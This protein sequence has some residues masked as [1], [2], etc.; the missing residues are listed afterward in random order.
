MSSSK[1]RSMKSYLV[2]QPGFEQIDFNHRKTFNE[3]AL[4]RNGSC[5]QNKPI[6]VPGYD[7]VLLNNTCSADSLLSILAVS[8][9]ESNNYKKY[10]TEGKNNKIVADFVKKIIGNRPSK[11]MYRD[12]VYL[13]ALHFIT[14]IKNLIG[15]IMLVNTVD[16][17]ASMCEKLLED[18][19]SYIRLDTCQNMLC[20]DKEK[21]SAGGVVITFL[22]VDGTIN[23]QKK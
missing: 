8:V 14:E 3:I 16:M 10:L 23:L 6:Y 21:S 12:R 18:M 4:L 17:A 15:G 1:P 2:K 22:G 11:E 7:K 19:P 9:A 5:F 13:L 20:F